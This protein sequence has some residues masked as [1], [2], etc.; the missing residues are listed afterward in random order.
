MSEASADPFMLALG[1][2]AE[3][4]GPGRAKVWG[5]VRPEHLN[6]H[7]SAHG[8]FIYS[9]AD[10]AFALASNSHDVPAVALST[11]IEYLEAGRAGD[12]L[13]AVAEE[14]YLG[15]RTAHYRVQVR[16]DA[17]LIAVFTGTVYRRP[18]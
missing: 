14:I 15:Y 4:L 13:E 17:K 7:G 18:D 3:V 2:Q 16:R 5:Q 11:H 10:G 1:L 8:G 12:E 9:L 6:M